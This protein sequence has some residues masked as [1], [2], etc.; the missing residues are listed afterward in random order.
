MQPTT[1]GSLTTGVVEATQM[2]L[3]ALEEFLHFEDRDLAAIDYAGWR[4]ALDEPL[5]RQGAGPR[6]TLETLAKIV[7]PHGVRIG[8]PGFSGW[9]NTT[10]T[11]VPALAA[12]SASLAGAQRAWL[13]SYNFLEYLALEWLK[14]LLAL[15]PT[16]QGI[17]NSGGSVANLIALGTAR[18]WACEQHGI[19]ASRDGLRKLQS[20]RLYSSNQ[21]H[22]V[23]QRAAAVLGLGRCGVTLLPTDNAFRLDVSALRDQL[24][25]D[26]AD[27]CTPI[28]VVASAGTVNTGAIDPLEEIARLCREE[29]VW[30]HVDGAYGAFG[31]LDPE[32]KPL[33][34]GLSEAD[35][36]A[37]DPHKWLA[38]PLGCGT[39]FVR[40]RELLARAFTLEPAEYLEGS[41]RQVQSIGS[42]F[43]D[44]GHVFHHF[45]VE[46]SAQS[47]GVTVWAALK[48]IGAE[49]MRARVHA[50]N[51][52]ARQLAARVQASP[53]LE[54]VAPVTLS[55]CCFRYV[56]L[57]LR[58]TNTVTQLLNGLNREILKRLHHEHRYVPSSTELNGAFAI[59]PCYINPRTTST[60]VDGLFQAVE[61]IGGQVWREHQCQD[62]VP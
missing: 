48:E 6:A 38:V 28:A 9:V 4:V 39:T 31:V 22:H 2:I 61:R 12:F 42:Q 62:T 13:Q 29:R 23:V 51:S 40:D 5:P 15:P 60:D 20:P 49:G 16:L 46:Q 10:P 26:R 45:T 14:Q 1:D 59:R 54:L 57:E 25:R 8:A 35:S 32:V 19:D 27:G 55:I 3:P 58:A 36:I 34:A 30:L 44:F 33:F 53:V 47:R 21:V 7:I 52:F 24:R 37:V 41:V 56:P 17:F 43:D 50:H 18:Q 11:I